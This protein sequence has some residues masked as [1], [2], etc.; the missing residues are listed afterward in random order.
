[1]KTTMTFGLAREVALIVALGAGALTTASAADMTVTPGPFAPP[2][3]YPQ[4][5]A[6]GVLAP[7]PA[8]PL[9][10]VYDWTGFYVGLN[11]GGASGTVPWNSQPNM[12]TGSQSMSGGMVGG[13]AGYNLQTAEPYVFGVEADLDWASMKAAIAPAACAGQGVN[14]ANVICELRD[15]LFATTRLRFGYAFDRFLPY[16][17]GGVAIAWLKADIVGQPFGQAPATQLGWTAGAGVEYAITEALRAKVEY[18][19]AD[20]NG[21]S[22]NAPCGGGPVSFNFTTNVI[23]AGLNYRLWVR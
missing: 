18:L 2:P 16:V 5:V 15:P 19:H 12:I 13:T 23:R 17:T 7:P 8:Y 3:A 11:G 9:V 22:C 10:K 14:G 20:V 21:F 6:P 1:M 4:A